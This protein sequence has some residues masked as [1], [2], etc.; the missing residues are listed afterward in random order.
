MFNKNNLIKTFIVSLFALSA[1][2]VNAAS[3]YFMPQEV[4]LNRGQEVVLDLKVNTNDNYINA[5][6][7]SV[8]FPVDIL[9]FEGLDKS[10]SLFNFWLEDPAV[11]ETDTGMVKFSAGTPKGFSG[12]SLQIVKLRFTAVGSGV[13]EI[14][15]T[16]ALVTANDGKGTNV[17]SETKGAVVNVGVKSTF[18]SVSAIVVE[19]GATPVIAEEPQKV[20]REA[21]LVTGEKLPAKPELRIPLYPDQTKWYGVLGEAAVFWNLPD[22]VSGVAVKV[23]RSPNTKPREAE[24][25]LFTG[26]KFTVSD[27]GVWYAHVRF[28]NNVGW[29]ETSHHKISVDTSAPASFEIAMDNTATDN[30]T[31]KI[32]FDTKDSFSGVAS[33]MIYVRLRK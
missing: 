12:S 32:S 18:P 9:K 30:P 13:A 15:I 10:G 1:F 17:L 7:A 31:P 3:L 2:S 20:E 29:G 26:K 24:A 21:V 25:G 14:G 4:S 23:D 8:K 19:K 11:S 16:D 27:E 33:A 6:Q 22:D 5:S 28:R